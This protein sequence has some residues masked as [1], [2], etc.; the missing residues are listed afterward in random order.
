M[1]PDIVGPEVE[2]VRGFVVKPGSSFTEGQSLIE[3]LTEIPP[4][5]RNS[6]AV[7]TC[8][9]AVSSTP[10][11]NQLEQIR[12][13]LDM[14]RMRTKLAVADLSRL[15]AVVRRTEERLQSLQTE[16]ALGRSDQRLLWDSHASLKYTCAQQ[17]EQLRDI[18]AFFHANRLNEVVAAAAASAAAAAKGVG[19]N[20]P[21]ATPTKDDLRIQ[22][23]AHRKEVQR[24]ATDAAPTVSSFQRSLEFWMERLSPQYSPRPGEQAH[25]EHAMQDHVEADGTSEAC[26]DAKEIRPESTCAEQQQQQQQ[27]QQH[28]FQ[29]THGAQQGQLLE[30]GVLQWPMC[31]GSGE[32]VQR[33]GRFTVFA[34]ANENAPEPAAPA[35]CSLPQQPTLASSSLD[36]SA[37]NVE[38][39]EFL[40]VNLEEVHTLLASTNREFG[41]LFGK[42]R[43][44]V[45]DVMV[46][47]GLPRERA[48]KN[49][50]GNSGLNLSVS[51]SAA[52][53]RHQSVTAA[54][55]GVS[56]SQLAEADEALN[57]W[58]T[59]GKPIE[60]TTKR[61]RA[62][63]DENKRLK[64][65][66]AAKMRELQE[67]QHRAHAHMQAQAVSLDGSASTGS[68]TRTSTPS[69]RSTGNA[70]VLVTASASSS[71]LGNSG[72]PALN[73]AALPSSGTMKA[74]QVATGSSSSSF[75]PH[76]ELSAATQALLDVNGLSSGAR[77]GSGVFGHGFEAAT[78]PRLDDTSD[79]GG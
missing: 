51:T 59:L 79:L 25:R 8:D 10:E 16:V 32:Q 22:V 78:P 53:S 52:S 39:P 62:L 21:Y 30:Q 55:V 42:M 73:E 48:A 43:A 70:P 47:Q 74:T 29:Q 19:Q 50:N 33:L 35:H 7:G 11:D 31:V 15:E 4:Y 64:R 20:N 75:A 46:A 41:T 65:E 6:T 28:E 17:A 23:R 18:L 72:P 36:K 38:N 13:E 37:L 69:R 76:A 77:T 26:A 45:L 58:E 40:G 60:R 57:L 5:S 66:V 63:E 2:S 49:R 67:L 44:H 14:E 27:Q 12:S 61:N 1:R 71:L 34:P 68:S 56:S 24:S 3:S 9:K 54:P